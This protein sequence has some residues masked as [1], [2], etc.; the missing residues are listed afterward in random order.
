MMSSSQIVDGRS[1]AEPDSVAVRMTKHTSYGFAMRGSG[2]RPLLKSPRLPAFKAA[3]R[4]DVIALL[5]ILSSA[6]QMLYHINKG[7]ETAAHVAAR[8]GAVNSIEV[9]LKAAP[10]LFL[11]PDRMGRLPANVISCKKN[12]L[13]IASTFIII[14]LTSCFGFL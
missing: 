12:R 10:S 6:P 7:G 8:A 14:F 9:L 11:V 4:G 1:A 5:D 2:R 3:E 13:V